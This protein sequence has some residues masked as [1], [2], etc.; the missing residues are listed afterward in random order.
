M[1]VLQTGQ[2]WSAASPARFSPGRRWRRGP[3]A[4]FAKAAYAE[5][6][7]TDDTLAKAFALGW[8]G[9]ISLNTPTIRPQEFDLRRFAREAGF[10]EHSELADTNFLELLVDAA[11]KQ[12]RIE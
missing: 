10:P 6:S 8:Y 7:A 5:L 9:V 1:P 4:K 11:R 2:H 3:A 12:V